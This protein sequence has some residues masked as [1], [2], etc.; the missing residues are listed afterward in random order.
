MKKRYITWMSAFV[1]LMMLVLTGCQSIGGVD[2]NKALQN[3]LEVAS[4]EGTSNFSIELIGGSDFDWAA[5]GEDL[6]F[7]NNL[8]LE[9]NN[10]KMQDRNTLSMDAALVTGKGKFPFSVSMTKEEIAVQFEGAAKPVYLKLDDYTSIDPMMMTINWAGLSETLE[11]NQE[12]LLKAVGPFIINN[13]PNPDNIKVSNTSEQIDGIFTNLTKVQVEIKGS[14]VLDLLKA[15]IDNINANDQALKEVIQQI[16]TLVIDPVQKELQGEIEGL[17]NGVDVSPATVDEIYN[18]AKEGLTELSLEIEAMKNSG[19]ADEF[20]NENNYMKVD[21]YVDSSSQIRKMDM[22]L[23]LNNPEPSNDDLNTIKIKSTSEMWNINHAV[24]A[25]IINTQDGL[26]VE[27]VTMGKFLKNLDANSALYKLMVDDLGLKSKYIYLPIW[28]EVDG[29]LYELPYIDPVTEKAM[30][31]VRFVT[32]ELDAD[33]TWDNEKRQVT[34]V[35][36]WTGKTIVM[37][38]ESSTATVDGVPVE[39]EGVATLQGDTTYV[40]LRF[41]A[42]TFGAEVNWDTEDWAVIITRD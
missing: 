12:Q 19:E 28:E 3:N 29:E 10:I 25:D 7:L 36:I 41:I 15:F 31:P 22:E 23:V 5:D 1:G 33:V 26:N 6:S 13:L 24:K 34:V 32:E 30:A 4:Y 2:L 14:E 38:I 40:P 42:E 16:F 37:T 21:M 8:Q 9:M 20:L 27:S 35:D 18:A 17:D 39:M 11:N